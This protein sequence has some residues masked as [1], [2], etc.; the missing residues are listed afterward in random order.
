MSGCCR[1]ELSEQLA[2]KEGFLQD[3][4]E[5]EEDASRATTPP[6]HSPSAQTSDLL[7]SDDSSDEGSANKAALEDLQSQ[8]MMLQEEIVFLRT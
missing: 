2:L 4:Q 6:K 5:E 1:D 7:A 3:I 8:N